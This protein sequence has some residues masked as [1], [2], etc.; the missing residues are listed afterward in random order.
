MLTYR[1]R[2][3]L[4][5]KNKKQKHKF[6]SMFSRYSSLLLHCCDKTLTRCNLGVGFFFV[7]GG[8]TGCYP[9]SRLAKRKNPRQ[10]PE[11][12]INGVMLP[13]DLLPDP[14]SYTSL[15]CLPRAG[16]HPKWKEA[17]LYQLAIKNMPHIHVDRQC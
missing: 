8:L 5:H 7:G 17:F 4:K 6:R 11:G 16:T 15:T 2:T 9:S 1:K 13:T 14:S 10:E 12:K 3:S